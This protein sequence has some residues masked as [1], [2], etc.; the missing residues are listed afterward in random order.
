MAKTYYEMQATANVGLKI[1]FILLYRVH[2]Y[3]RS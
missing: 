2:A 1:Q 3:L